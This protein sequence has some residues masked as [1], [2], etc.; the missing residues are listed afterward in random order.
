MKKVTLKRNVARVVFVLYLVALLSLVFGID[1]IES[2]EYHYNLVLFSE[3]KRYFMYRDVVG[4]WVFLMNIVGNILGFLPF[5]FLLPHLS[6][7]KNNIV[8]ATLLTFELSLFIEVI[9]LFTKVGS[10]DVDD[11]LLNTL[12]GFIGYLIFLATSG[13]NK[14]KQ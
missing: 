4:N 7:W 2:D 3:I 14:K 10:F 1:R 5:G 9:Q 11:L 6:K 12:G 8:F 13:M